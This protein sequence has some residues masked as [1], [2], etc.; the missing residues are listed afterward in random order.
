MGHGKPFHGDTMPS[1]MAAIQLVGYL[2]VQHHAG[3]LH[4]YPLTL[5]TCCLWSARLYLIS[6]HPLLCSRIKVMFL[7]LGNCPKQVFVLHTIL[8]N[9]KYFVPTLFRRRSRFVSSK[10]DQ[11]AHL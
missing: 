9:F 6:L 3:L 2:E 4:F 1:Q 5:V 11:R 7:V 8:I 10:N